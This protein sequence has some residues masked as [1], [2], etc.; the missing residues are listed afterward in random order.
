MLSGRK[1]TGTSWRKSAAYQIAFAY[2]AAF[3]LGVAL[4]GT[5]I[6]IAMHL[7]FIHELDASITDEA[8]G[9][10]S[11][12]RTDGVG[13]LRDAITQR[14]AISSRSRMLY[15]VFSPSG[16][17]I[18][19]SLQTPRPALGLHDITFHDQEEG[20]DPAR[21]YAVD[22][23]NGDRLLV[24]ADREAVERADNTVIAIFA[25]GFCG[26][27]LLG[28]VGALVLGSY[29]R[30]RLAAISAG[31][32]AI[33]AGDISRRMQVSSRDD[34][35]D[36]LAG[37]LNTMLERIE[38]LLENLRQVSSDIAH[39]LRTPLAQLRNRL[40][41]EL[42]EAKPGSPDR[43]VLVDAMRRV[44]EIL[45]L[46]AAILRIS[47][48]ESGQIRKR[49]EPVNLSSL[50]TEIAESYAPA[51]GEGGRD[52]TW[53]IEPE[54]WL[55]G[56]RELIAQAIINLLENAQIHTPAGVPIRM[57][58]SG[59]AE[60]IV[61]EIIDSGPGVPVEE[62]GRITRRFVR[63]DRSRST[64][65][66][67]LGLNLV[68]AVAQLHGAELVFADNHPGLVARIEFPRPYPKASANRDPSST[69]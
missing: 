64:S 34:E 55:P 48:I 23:P 39:D 2:S 7:A 5:M 56:D 30:R 4:L 46:F 24:A 14:E 44:D 33:I 32:N 69:T 35:F 50:A 28:I 42:V 8:A 68:D 15:A 49:F 12:Y 58:L 22:L 52:L 59:S 45:S 31:A 6:F 63:L 36:R 66:H 29:L 20:A 61:L 37:T 16:Q 67:G 10:V 21:G 57:N 40:E 25:L 26:V 38:R 13:E 60:A 18:Y 27:A 65:G 51:L 17:R 1:R 9:L 19:G 53:T 41:Y 43:P 47:E 54:L 3:A 11:E 62:R